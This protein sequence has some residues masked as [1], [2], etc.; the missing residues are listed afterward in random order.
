MKLSPQVAVK[1]R[2]GPLSCQRRSDLVIAFTL[3][4]ASS[5]IARTYR[6]VFRR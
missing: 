3:L 2:Q 1:P 5:V 4:I 6:N